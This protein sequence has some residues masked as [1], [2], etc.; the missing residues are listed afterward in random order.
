M[1]FS[2]SEDAYTSRRSVPEPDKIC[3][4][5]L[6]YEKSFFFAMD[7]PASL[8]IFMKEDFILLRL[9]VQSIID[10]MESCTFVIFT[11]DF[12]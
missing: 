7:I 11:P 4:S 12:T 10:P 8:I 5:A 1:Y 6:S 9:K 2:S 3:L